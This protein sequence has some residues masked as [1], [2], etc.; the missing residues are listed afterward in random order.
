[1]ISENQEYKSRNENKEN[2]IQSLRIEKEQNEANIFKQQLRIK[3]LEEANTSY[4]NMKIQ[5]DNIVS[6]TKILGEKL[7]LYR[8]YKSKFMQLSKAVFDFSGNFKN[9]I[10]QKLSNLE[11]EKAKSFLE[12]EANSNQLIE[13][14]QVLSEEIQQS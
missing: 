6:Q 10:I 13:K 5:F 9:L 3:E 11:E 2:E 12:W 1:M 8:D 7:M 14:L 4:L